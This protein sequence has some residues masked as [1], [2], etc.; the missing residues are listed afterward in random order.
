M[1]LEPLPDTPPWDPLSYPDIPSLTFLDPAILGTETADSLLL[2]LLYELLTDTDSRFAPYVAILPP[3]RDYAEYWMTTW[4][5]ETRREWARGG[6]Y[7]E[8][9][10]SH[11]WDEYT[12]I[13]A[14][15]RRVCHTHGWDASPLMRRVLCDSQLLHWAYITLHAR[16][17]N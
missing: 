12:S 2:R 13:Q 5:E 4:D 6:A 16:G 9:M 14:A 3:M 15:G 1:P 10:F 17:W 7:P 8:L 11:L